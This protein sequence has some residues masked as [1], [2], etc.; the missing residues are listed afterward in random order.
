MYQELGAN[1][2]NYGNF[3]LDESTNGDGDCWSVHLNSEGGK[4]FARKVINKMNEIEPIE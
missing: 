4:R 2:W 3:F 1:M